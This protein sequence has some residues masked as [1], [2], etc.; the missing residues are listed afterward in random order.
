MNILLTGAA[1]QLGSE[2]LPLL[3]A[4]GNLTVTDRKKPV[5]AQ[6]NWLELD[7]CDGG[8]LEVLLDRLQPGLI[9]NTA[10][11]TAV[12]Q[13]EANRATAFDVNAE[14]PSRLA[15][16][17]KRNNARLLH[18]STD[19]VFDGENSR[20]YLE[21]DLANPQNVYGESKLAGESA[22]QAAGCKYA[23]LRTSWVYSSHGKNFVLSMLELA[24]RGLLLK[25]VD[26]QQGCPT[27]ARNLAHASVAVIEAWKADDSAESNGVFHY[28]DDRSLCWHDFASTI[29]NLAVNAGLLDSLPRLTPVPGK[30]FPQ[31]AKRPKWSVLDTGKI[32]KIF[33][34]RP[35][36]FESS[37]Q[38]VIDEIK[39]RA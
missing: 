24:R 1:G 23:I 19:Y 34:I 21:T 9:V 37:L 26:D 17:A 33:N 7:I 20:P 16:W 27:W 32:N 10:A 28:C 36:S 3:S 13:A 14:L 4:R 29:F 18:Y 25:I 35:A 15:V 38:A 30:A 8:R 31:P 5:L 22:L 12:D 2:L 6:G 39:S 11:Y